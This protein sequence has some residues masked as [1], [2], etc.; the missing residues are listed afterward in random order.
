MTKDY[1]GDNC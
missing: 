1:V